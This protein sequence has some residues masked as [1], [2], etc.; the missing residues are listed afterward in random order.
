MLDNDKIKT[1]AIVTSA[2]PYANGEIHLGH[3]AS[4]YLPAD[5]FTRFSRLLGRTI[6]HVCAS[7]DYGTPVL[8][9]AEKEKQTPAQYVAFWNKRDYEDFRSLG[10][11]FDF[12]YRTSSKENVEL[13]QYVFEK[14]NENGYI[15][16]D[17]VIQFYCAFDDKFL[18]DRYI[19]GKCP[20]CGAEN[21]YS[22]QCEKCG[23]I[24]DQILEAKCAI[25]GRPPTKK[26]SKHYFFKLSSFSEQLRTWL[27]NNEHLQQDVKS[28]V[29]NWI[30]Q[31]LRDWDITRDLSW[32]IQIPLNH[33]KGKVFYGWF[34]NHICYISTFNAFIEKLGY[35]GK[36]LWNRSEIYH[37]IGKDIVYH[38]YLFLPAIRMGINEEYKLPDYIPC[39]GHLM[40][41]NQKISKSRSWY[42]GLRDFLSAFASDYLRFYIASISS[43]SQSDINFDWNTFSEKINN[44]LIANIGNFINRALSFVQNIFYGK[45]PEPSIYDSQDHDSIVEINGIAHEVG[46]FLS[47]NELDKALKRILKFGIY[48]NQYFQKKQPWSKKT[49][50]QTTLFIAVNA[51]R[52]MAIILEPFIPF[53]CEKVWSQLGMHSDVHKQEWLSA[54]QMRVQSGH[55][56]GKIEPIFYKIEPKYIEHYK[57][58]LGKLNV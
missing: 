34:D 49:T 28:Y 41:H 37:F 54:S 27:I 33:A 1:S 26:S 10:I 36:Q 14:L 3:I 24:P 29:I 13:V 15:Y 21:Q 46:L 17:D 16:E 25:C 9:K 6:Y 44:E 52:S 19:I 56:L 11:S 47:Q 40:L 38:H 39:R 45:V 58:K 12:F 22:D 8:I 5:I 7:D 20:Y 50:A 42:I 18:P 35:N 32:G 55:I 57:S 31:G 51:V 30:D 48:F 53:S 43:Y 2:L 4:T 23:R